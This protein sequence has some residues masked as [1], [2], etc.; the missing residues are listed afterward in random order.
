MGTTERTPAILS[1][2]ES[3]RRDALVGRLFDAF[4]AAADLLSVYVGDA[5]GLYRSL[6][7]EGPATSGQL[8]AR[9]G[10]AERYAREW[11]EQQAVTGILI[12]DDVAKD[13][14]HRE[15]ALPPEHAEPLTDLDSL[16]SIVPLARF[17]PP[18]ISVMPKLLAAYRS[19]AGVSWAEY[20]DEL[21][22]SQGDFN[23]PLF[24]HQLAQEILPQIED[25]HAALVR[26]ARVADIACGVGW[27]SIAIAKGFPNTRVDGLDLDE[28]AVEA[29]RGAAADAGVADRVTFHIS[30]AADPAHRARYDLVTIFEAV[31]DFSRPVEILRA[32][33]E[34]LVEG[35]SVLV[36]DERVAESFSAPANDIERLMYAFSLLVCLPN[37]LAEQPSAGTGTVMR[38]DTLRAYAT[39]AGFTE[40][41]VLGIEHPFFRFYR[42]RR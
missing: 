27:S 10:L 41:E 29:A 20:G 36:M 31:H 37:G 12:V 35:G 14:A 15:Y 42:L 18:A 1:D 25:V 32:A 33:H 2:A 39:A 8:A 4:L 30:D 9:A 16:N 23:R 38:P 24:R 34:M 22:Q 7:N 11:L 21:W 3:G 13:A 5:L 40:V 6:A 28:R 17:L 26:G 19:G